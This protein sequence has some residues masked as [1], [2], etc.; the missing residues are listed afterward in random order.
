M[1]VVLTCKG[2]SLTVEQWAQRQG[3]NKSTIKSRLRSG[4][5]AE[6]AVFTK[7]DKRFSRISYDGKR[8]GPKTVFG[9]DLEYFATDPI[10]ICELCLHCTKPKCK[11]ECR[12]VRKRYQEIREKF[13]N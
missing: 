4:W 6:A 10:E 2:V 8:S 3:I 5:T 1:A 7:V 12:E 13:E 11:G 9:Y